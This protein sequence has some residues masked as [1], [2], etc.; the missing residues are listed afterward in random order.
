MKLGLRGL[1]LRQLGGRARRRTPGHEGAHAAASCRGSGKGHPPG[2]LGMDST[3]ARACLTPQEWRG[4]RPRSRPPTAE[5][6]PTSPQTA[7]S[8]TTTSMLGAAVNSNIVSIFSTG[9]LAQ[10][11]PGAR[12]WNRTCAQQQRQSERQQKQRETPKAT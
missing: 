6:G 10:G 9:R 4:P 8:A 1:D 12:N 2:A 3:S 5:T 7:R 11:R